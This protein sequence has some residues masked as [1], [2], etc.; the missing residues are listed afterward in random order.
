VLYVLM[1]ILRV[2]VGSRVKVNLRCVLAGSWH[3]EEL[4]W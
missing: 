2:V 1:V 3:G 4:G